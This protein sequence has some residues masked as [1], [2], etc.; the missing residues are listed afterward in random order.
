MLLKGTEF[1]P[2]SRPLYWL[3]PLPRVPFRQIGPLPP[4]GHQVASSERPSLTTW[5]ICN[6]LG[7]HTP[8][9]LFPALMDTGASID[10]YRCPKQLWNAF[11]AEGSL[12]IPERMASPT[13]RATN[14]T[15]VP[16]LAIRS[17]CLE[18]R[19]TW[20]RGPLPTQRG[21]G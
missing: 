8:D 3:C 10:G 4:S 1:G 13:P 15:V 6:P 12:R 18:I 5:F 21:Q 2:A 14:L 16:S 11:D 20:L 9:F 7:W 17:C 19:L